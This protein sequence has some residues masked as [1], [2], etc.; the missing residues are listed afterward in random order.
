MATFAPSAPTAD[1]DAGRPRVRWPALVAFG[2]LLLRDARVLTRERWAF[3]VRTISQP[4]LLVFVFTYVFPTIGQELRAFEGEA[5]FSEVLVPGVIAI[6]MLI[7]G[8]QAVALPLVDDFGYT[9]EIEDRVMAPLP[10]WAV[11]LEKIVSGALQGLLAVAV[12]FPIVALVPAEPVTLA[13]SWGHLIAIGLLAPVVGASVGLALG[14]IVTPKQVPIMFS[15]VILP[16]TFLGATYFPW[17][18]L[19]AIP[20]LQWAVLINPL[21]YLSEGFRMALT[22]LPHMPAVGIYAGMAI[23]GG[24]T[25]TIGMWGFYRRVL[26]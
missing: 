17:T 23:C 4:V 8:L 6:T 7:K 5:T 2:G 25:A 12:V 15:I 21:V 24:I 22:P 10:V 13:I 26:A 1:D 9:R 19:D 11:A 18:Q 3:A 16:V 20:W 14:T